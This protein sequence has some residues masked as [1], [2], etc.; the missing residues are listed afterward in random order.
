[1]YVRY[2]KRLHFGLT[3]HVTRKTLS[4]AIVEMV[5]TAK[6]CDYSQSTSLLGKYAINYMLVLTLLPAKPQ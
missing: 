4:S 2:Y 1:M 5:N 6:N 3:Y